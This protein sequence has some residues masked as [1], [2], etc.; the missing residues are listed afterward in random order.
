MLRATLWGAGVRT[1]GWETDGCSARARLRGLPGLGALDK[2]SVHMLSRRR[3]GQAPPDPWSPPHLGHRA[4]GSAHSERQ[5]PSS[6]QEAQRQVERTGRWSGQHLSVP[7][8]ASLGQ[9]AV[10]LSRSCPECPPSAHLLKGSLH[11]TPASSFPFLPPPPQFLSSPLGPVLTCLQPEE[12]TL[13]L[14]GGQGKGTGAR[15]AGA[16][17]QAA[18]HRPRPRPTHSPLPPQ[19]KGPGPAPSPG[20]RCLA[21]SAGS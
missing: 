20:A 5:S 16:P 4:A 13:C 12:K 14:S 9:L 3:T 21:P 8:M 15:A 10:G 1:R 18:G 11:L 7:R 19:W 6:R 17:A 2:S